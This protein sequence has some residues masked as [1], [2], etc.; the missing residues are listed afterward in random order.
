MISLVKISH[1]CDAITRRREVLPG[2][3]QWNQT[4]E[5]VADHSYAATYRASISAW[6]ILLLNRPASRTD[7]LA[8]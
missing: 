1:V 7:H 6:A 5:L 3:T 4:A 2:G 8:E